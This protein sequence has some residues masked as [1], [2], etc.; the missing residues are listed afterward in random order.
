VLRQ[1]WLT[2]DELSAEEAEDV[3]FGIDEEGAET[4]NAVYVELG[5]DFEAERSRLAVGVEDCWRSK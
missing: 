5:E 4:S 1:G 2:T 3:D